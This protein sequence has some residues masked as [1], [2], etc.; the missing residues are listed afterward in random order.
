MNNEFNLIVTYKLVYINNNISKSFI[1]DLVDV[2]IM[3]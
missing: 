3:Y 1:I 2:I